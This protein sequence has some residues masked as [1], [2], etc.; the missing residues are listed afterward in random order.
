MKKKLTSGNVSTIRQ[1]TETMINAISS[2]AHTVAALLD[3]G[4]FRNFHTL[5]AI[6]SHLDFLATIFLVPF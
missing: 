1:V 4:L 5:F 2:Q 3:L 6:F